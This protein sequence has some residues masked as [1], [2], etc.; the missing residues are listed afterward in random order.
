MPAL[1]TIKLYHNG[2]FTRFPDVKYIDGNIS[3]VDMVDIDEFSVH[4][5]NIVIKGLGYVVPLMI[6]YHLRI[7]NCDFIVDFMIWV[8]KKM[9]ATLLS[10]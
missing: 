8:T 4:Q 5:L 6:Y 7:S 10:L 9:Y 1:F 3:Y 2:E